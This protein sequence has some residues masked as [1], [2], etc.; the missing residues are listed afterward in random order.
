MPRGEFMKQTIMLIVNFLKAQNYDI[1][2][3]E[4]KLTI[5][6]HNDDPWNHFNK[7]IARPDGV[8]NYVEVQM[9]G[10]DEKKRVSCNDFETAS[11]LALAMYVSREK[12][13]LSDDLLL[14]KI[15]KQTE[16]MI[17]NSSDYWRGQFIIDELI[18]LIK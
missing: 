9:G 4:N 5:V 18:S 17:N 12:K 10:Y 2:V 11:F 3:E 1:D 7:F 6:K 16:F 8:Y 15:Q 14:A 13:N